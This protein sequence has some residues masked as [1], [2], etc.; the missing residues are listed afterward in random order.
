VWT[1]TTI[2]FFSVV[3]ARCEGGRGPIDPDL[4]MIRARLRSH[5]IA[6]QN[7]FPDEAGTVPI[8]E[9][10]HADYRFRI[11]VPKVAWARMLSALVMEDLDYANY[12]SAAA[13]ANPGPEGARFLDALHRTWSVM[14]SIERPRSSERP[15]SRRR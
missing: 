3:C 11:I 8:L 10:A 6:L 12:K 4:V 15:D 2:G 13:A 14:R 5:L 7:R 1:A 9:S